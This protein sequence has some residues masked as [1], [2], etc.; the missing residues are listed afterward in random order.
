M[1]SITKARCEVVDQIVEWPRSDG[2]LNIE[3]G[4][5]ILHVR[6]FEVIATVARTPDPQHVRYT[7]ESSRGQGRYARSDELVGVRRYVE[8]TEE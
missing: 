2:T 7:L 1:D 6:Q 5:L 8:T 4:D 3:P